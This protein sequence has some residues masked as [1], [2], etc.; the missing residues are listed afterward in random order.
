M[1]IPVSWLFGVVFLGCI[2]ATIY[3]VSMRRIPNV[4]TVG[5]MV[6]ALAFSIAHGFESVARSFGAMSVVLIL[7]SFA[8][9]RGVIGGGDVKLAA[10][11][12]AAVAAALSLPAALA[13]V[14]YTLVSGGVLA[15]IV[16]ALEHRGRLFARMR[17]MFANLT[18]GIL[19]PTGLGSRKM[20]YALAIT[21]GLMLVYGSRTILPFLRFA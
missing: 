17:T 8:H 6:I 13:F 18:I 5:L 4:L 2:L 1:E 7:G 10:A 15:L 11:V 16:L 3:D 20:P 19:P 21:C 9:A 14:L 12:A